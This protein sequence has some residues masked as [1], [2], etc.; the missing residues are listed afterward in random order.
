MRPRRN[1]ANYLDLEY[2]GALGDGRTVALSG[3]D[4][5]L[6]WWCVPN[7]DSPPLFDRLLDPQDGGYFSITP[8]QDFEVARTYRPESNVLET[9]F[10]TATGKARMVESLNS[11][12][13]G[14]LPWCELARRV[15]GM[16]GEVRF[17][18]VLRLGQRAGTAS[19]YMQKVAGHDVFHVGDVLGLFLRSSGISIQH[20]GDDGAIA[21]LTIKEGETELLAIVAGEGE[22]LVAPSLDEISARIDGSDA[23]WRTWASLIQCDGKYREALVRSAL[24]LKFLLFSPSGAI[25]AAAT[26]SLPER[27]G[28]P[29][30]Y[31][32]RFAWVRDAGYTIN[33]FL[34]VG[35]QAEAKAALTWLLK[36]IEDVGSRVCYSIWGGA[37]P[38]VRTIDLPGYYRSRPVVAGNRATDQRQHGIYGDIFET[39][40]C[41]VAHGNILDARSAE[42]LSHLADECTNLWR[43][44]DSGI[45]E[46]AEEQH[47]T[48]S[49]ISCWQAL[50]R[51]VELA[52]AGQ[53][54]TT[55]RDRWSRERDRIEAWIVEHCWSQNLGAYSFYP[56][57]DRLDASL[58]LA[59]RFGFDGEDRLR[60]TIEAIDRELGCGPFHYRYSGVE[61][62][63]GCFLACTFWMVEAKTLLGDREAATTAFN[64]ALGGL[65]TSVGIYPEMIDPVAGRYLGNMPQGL[66]HLAIIQAIMSLQEA[67]GTIFPTGSHP[68]S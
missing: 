21:N 1:A 33:A 45:W 61:A 57:T 42:I 24:A 51:A 66:T 20:L 17:D 64:A 65:A 14:R 47:Y 11:G 40:A 39:A 53:L 48:M 16:E 49:K 10:T 44:K 67:G 29:K 58:A 27:I 3:A 6:D 26:S 28:G 68:S 63:E 4:G 54:P 31:D 5:S 59:V 50:A 34:R 35:A 60:R 30:N 22:P 38:E 19:P 2:Y 23:E 41:F 15:E 62:E 7:L 36:Q 8:F 43:Q 13:A 55:C 18:I 37:V 25:A 56:G 46:L 52:D 12:S 32:Y 9:I